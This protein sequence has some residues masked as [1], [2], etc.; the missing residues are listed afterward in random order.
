MILNDS[1]NPVEEVDFGVVKRALIILGHQM[2]L[3]EHTFY[4]NMKPAY[5]F[6]AMRA[7]TS[8]IDA[9][10]EVGHILDGGIDK[11]KV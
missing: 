5:A 1:S 2:A 8:L 11:I 3:A 6:K 9:I 7:K 4:K 10:V